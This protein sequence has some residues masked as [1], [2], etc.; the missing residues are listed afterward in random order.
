MGCPCLLGSG[1]VRPLGCPR[2]CPRVRQCSELPASAA[3]ALWRGHSATRSVSPDAASTRTQPPAPPRGQALLY[4]SQTVGCYTAVCQPAGERERVSRVSS[5]CQWPSK[6]ANMPSPTQCGLSLEQAT[7]Q[8]LSGR[9]WEE[10]LFTSTDL[11]RS[12]PSEPWLPSE[13]LSQGK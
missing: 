1:A 10:A 9:G 5:T 2:L 3:E 8:A 6:Q 7:G 13:P 4:Y 11:A 12:L